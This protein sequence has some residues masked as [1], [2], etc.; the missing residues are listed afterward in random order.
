MSRSVG[1]FPRA[2]VTTTALLLLA[3]GTRPTHGQP[4]TPPAARTFFPLLA[5]DL[6]RDGLAPPPTAPAPWTATARVTP[7]I[8]ATATPTE[9]LPDTPTPAPTPTPAVC[10]AVPTFAD[11]LAPLREIHVATDGDDT[12]GDGSPGAPF[13]TIGRAARSAGPGDAIRVAAGRY[14]GGAHYV[15]NLRGRADAPIWI[16]GAAP[17]D[18]PILQ[19]GGQGLHLSRTAYLVVHDLVVRDASSNGINAD[20]GGDVED[21]TASHHLVFR[22]LRIED[23]GG[24]GNQDC[25]KLS[26]LRDVVVDGLYAAHC[27]GGSS[28]SGV[29]MVGVHRAVVARSWFT[30]MSGGALQ[31]KG[32]S[33]DVEFRWNRVTDGGARGVNLGGSTGAPYFRPPLTRGVDTPNAE[34]RDIRVVANLFEGGDAPVAFVGC[35]DCLVAHNTIVAPR[36]W[37]AR[38]LQESR[39]TGELHFEPTHDGRFLN[40]LVVVDRAQ[41]RTWVNVGGGT[42]PDTFTFGRN[43]WYARDEPG[44]S[45]PDL[46]VRETDGIVGRDPLLGPDGR[47]AAESPAAGA[48]RPGVAPGVRGDLGG[49]CRP[50]PPSIGAREP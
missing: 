42:E 36:R 43:L 12:G 44:R 1:G 32:G 46:P 48:G 41:L 11:G 20:D 34:A 38:I 21:P 6:A 24:S 8:Q 35:V 26:G 17:A 4:P 50:D 9:P 16:G 2:A 19:A 40:N 29:D 30:A 10:G 39:T 47:I 15:E 25:L 45:A 28:G 37:V 33:T 31:A 23:I 7:P 3:F 27:G 14:F 18:P 49:R 13:A 5:H 22:D